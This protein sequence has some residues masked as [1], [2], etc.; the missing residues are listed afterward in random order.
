MKYL[1]LSKPWTDQA[2]SEAYPGCAYDF[3]NERMSW[4]TRQRPE[5]GEDLTVAH[6]FSRRVKVESPVGPLPTDLADGAIRARAFSI[7]VA[8]RLCVPNSL[9]A[10]RSFSNTARWSSLRR[11]LPS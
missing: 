2:H 1:K 3:C 7:R 4:R 8:H 10:E 5:Q 11:F 6:N 9:R